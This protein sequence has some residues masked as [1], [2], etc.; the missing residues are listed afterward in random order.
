MKVDFFKFCKV[1]FAI[2]G[3]FA[4]VVWKIIHKSNTF[5]GYI[6]PYCKTKRI[7]YSGKLLKLAWR[8]WFAPI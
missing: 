5:L 8:K 2:L 6:M 1:F 4:G 7:F 3:I